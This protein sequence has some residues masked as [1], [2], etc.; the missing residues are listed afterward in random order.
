MDILVGQLDTYLQSS[1]VI[2]LFL[3]FAGGVLASLTPCIY[4]MIPITAGIIGHANVGGSRWRGFFLSLIY[5]AGMALT[6]T[7][8]GIFAAATGS[9]FGSIN[10]NP[11]TFLI[12]GNILLFFG[13]VMLDAVQLPTLSGSL[14]SRRIGLAGLF[15]AGMSSALVAGPCTTPILGSLL[16]YTA[17]SQSILT[18][19]LLL[20]MFS[21]GMGMLLLGVGTFS[22]FLTSLPRSGQWMVIIKKTLGV[23]MLVIAQYFFIKAGTLFL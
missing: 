23:C 13:L 9:F 1:L 15:I 14:V 7:A 8:L 3:A 17:S 16:L 6:Y 4:P 20:F 18:G 12:V 10:T 21:L 2:S 22:S 19:G 5:I 11:W